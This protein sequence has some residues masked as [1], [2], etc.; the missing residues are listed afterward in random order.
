MPELI[1]Q[2]YKA[3]VGGIVGTVML[4]GD[5]RGI[6]VY[7]N[8]ETRLGGRLRIDAG[9]C[10]AVLANYVRQEFGLPRGEA[11]ATPFEWI[12]FMP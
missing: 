7:Y 10:R 6:S 2:S 3:N 12:G 8:R 9:N 5:A 1:N 11:N 4:K